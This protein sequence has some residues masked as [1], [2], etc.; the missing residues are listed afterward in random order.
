MVMLYDNFGQEQIH[1]LQISEKWT[2]SQ[3][4]R[5]QMLS[6]S[7]P[8]INPLR[9]IYNNNND[10]HIAMINCRIDTEM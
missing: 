3:K 8:D 2:Q 9:G 5:A 6:G 1:S 10:K 7:Y 4:E